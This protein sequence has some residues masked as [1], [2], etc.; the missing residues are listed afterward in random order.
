MRVRAQRLGEYTVLGLHSNATAWP[1]NCSY[2]SFDMFQSPTLVPSS[3]PPQLADSPLRLV[4][5]RAINTNQDSALVGF[6]RKGAG[7]SC[8]H[9][10]DLSNTV[11]SLLW[12][13]H[14]WTVGL[15]R[16]GTTLQL[17]L[18]RTCN[19]EIAVRSSSGQVAG[20]ASPGMW[21]PQDHSESSC[22]GI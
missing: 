4:R 15:Q 21:R 7:A 22:T 2:S 11:G 3:P 20:M 8:R 6:G 14:H 1:N 19:L 13:K 12:I 17:F 10:Q 9:A 18:E 16:A 5:A